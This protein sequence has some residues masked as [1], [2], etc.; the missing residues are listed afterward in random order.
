MYLHITAM[1]S[2]F[3]FDHSGLLLPKNVEVDVG[4]ERRDFGFLGQ[5][6]Y[7]ADD[8]GYFKVFFRF[9]L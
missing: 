5:G 9:H 7:F 6:I 2:R 3:H 4:I 8:I 1:N